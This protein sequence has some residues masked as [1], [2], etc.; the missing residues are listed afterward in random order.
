[1]DHMLPMFSDFILLCIFL[2]AFYTFLISFST[3]RLSQ[4]PL[5]LS[6]PL[7]AFKKIS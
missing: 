1:M 2:C 5:I 6:V 7:S 4:L 3:S